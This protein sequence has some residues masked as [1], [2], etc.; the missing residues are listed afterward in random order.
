M[1][2]TSPAALKHGTV[3]KEDIQGHVLLTSLFLFEQWWQKEGAED[4]TWKR[5]TS[6]PVFPEDLSLYLIL[7]A[8]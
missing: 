1:T 3:M 4:R 2:D 6:I 7:P 8:I 5:G